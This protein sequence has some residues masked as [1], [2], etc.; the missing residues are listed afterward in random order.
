MKILKNIFLILFGY[1][2]FV[3]ITAGLESIVVSYLGS[4]SSI[5]NNLQ[6]NAIYTLII[7]IV[8]NILFYNLKYNLLR[9]IVY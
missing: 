5:F 2:M 6:E 8:I 7:Y 3:L 9:K 4:E 1:I